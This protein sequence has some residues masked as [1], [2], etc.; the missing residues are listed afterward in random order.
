MKALDDEEL[1]NILD[2]LLVKIVESLVEMSASECDIQEELNAPDRS[3]FTLLHYVRN[4]IRIVY[5]LM[6]PCKS[7]HVRVF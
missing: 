7:I 1:D 5:S 3:G 6:F 4:I 2:S